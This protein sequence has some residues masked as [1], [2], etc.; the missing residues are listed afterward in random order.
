MRLPKLIIQIPCFN[1]AATLGV[2]ID[3][4]PR[5]IPGVGS[6]EILIVDDGSTDR[7]TEVAREHGADIVVSHG[8][9]KGLARAFTTGIEAALEHGADIIVNTDADN[10]YCADDIPALIEPVLKGYA[11]I[12]IGTRPIQDI[13][14]FSPLKKRLQGL[15]SSVV[16]LASNTE[17][18]DAP[19]GFRAFSR[20]AA[21]ELYVLGD[22]TYTLETIIHAGRQN[23]EIK[24]VPVRVNEDLR[25]SRLVKSIPSYVKRS[26]STIVRFWLSYEAPK[27]FGALAAVFGILAGLLALPAL[28]GTGVGLFGFSL[29]ACL[30]SG[31]AA[32][33]TDLQVMNRKIL[34]DIRRRLRATQ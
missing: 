9:N 13:E 14:H 21:R 8:T 6:V 22:Y 19:S 5:E 15:G 25:P 2:A 18:E 32:V 24:T 30:I 10:Q 11:D 34:Q 7:T 29:L 20:E 4:L 12:V 1:E 17:V 16:R 3:A 27:V 23:Y 28:F 33:I 26:A 31:G